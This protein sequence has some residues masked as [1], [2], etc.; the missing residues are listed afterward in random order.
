MGL[1]MYLEAGFP[2]VNGEINW[3]EVI[4]WRKS[5][6]IHGW[7][8]RVVNDGDDPSGEWYPVHRNH[9]AALRILCMEALSAARD[10]EW[11]TA[12]TILPPTPGF[13]FGLYDPLPE[14]SED[15]RKYYIE[16]LEETVSKLEKVLSGAETDTFRYMGW[17]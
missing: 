3:Q 7:I 2:Q 17:W 1:D 4:Y 15:D 16:D 9:L 6:W 11:D 12:Q 10:G 14:W 8:V 5:N 13:F